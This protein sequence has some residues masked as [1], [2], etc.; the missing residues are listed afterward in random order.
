[1]A[2]VGQTTINALLNRGSE[3]EFNPMKTIKYHVNYDA[4][5]YN[6]KKI[7]YEY[8]PNIQIRFSNG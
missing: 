5:I 6:H 3:Q 2:T 1:M 8:K 4:Q 7:P